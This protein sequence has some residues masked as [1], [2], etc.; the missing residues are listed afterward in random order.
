MKAVY[1]YAAREFKWTPATVRGMLF[2]DFL[3]VFDFK[4]EVPVSRE[5]LN[6]HINRKRAAK[7][8][9]PMK[10]A[11]GEKK[12]TVPAPPPAPEQKKRRR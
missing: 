8:L 5:D 6:D 10:P 1:N 2:S 4:Q 12:A 3:A 9:P 11:P 7:G